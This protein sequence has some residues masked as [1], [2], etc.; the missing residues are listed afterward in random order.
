MTNFHVEPPIKASPLPAALAGDKGAFEALTE[1]HRRELMTHCY[2]MLGSPQDAEDLVQETFL[3]AWRRLSTYEGRAS[4]RAWLYKIATNACIDA[5]AHRPKRTLPPASYP[6][7][8]PQSPL[9]APVAEPVWLEPF[10]DELLA[11]VETAP[12][13]RIEARESIRLSFLLALQVLPPRQRCV[14]ILSDVLDWPAQELADLL[15]ASLASV[16]SLLHRARLTLK[17]SYLTGRREDLKAPPADKQTQK[18]L[19]RYVQAWENAD[20]DE[21]VALLTEE[22]TFAMPP[23]PLWFQ[24]ASAIRAFISVALLNREARGRWRLKPVRANGEPG[25]G[26][27]QRNETGTSYEAYALQV[28]SANDLKISTI[29]TFVQPSLLRFFGLPSE[30]AAK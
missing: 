4:F 23:I 26:W 27:Y 10:P 13:S 15:G 12:E 1:P 3:R 22:T 14:L 6:A 18:L 5:L 17:K 9:P 8:G 29:T 11:P 24:G 19:D 2:R 16:N 30:L 20:L 28:L 7:G 21:I 25:F